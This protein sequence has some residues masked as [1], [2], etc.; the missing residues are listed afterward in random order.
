M[1]PRGAIVQLLYGSANH[2]PAQFPDPD[3][4]K[5]DRPGIDRHVA[6]GRGTHFCLGAPLARL[7]T[8]VALQTLSRRF[9]EL[10]VPPQHLSYIPALST[11]TLAAL[12][13][14]TR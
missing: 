13:V 1:I 3:T 4:C 5:L 6:F 2:D 14:A 7:E 12:T 8:R 11:H 10:G 9:P